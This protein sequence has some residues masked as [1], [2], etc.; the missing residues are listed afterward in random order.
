M[1]KRDGCLAARYQSLTTEKMYHTKFT[2]MNKLKGS[3]LLLLLFTT[4]T[5]I[6][7]STDIVINR[8]AAAIMPKVIEW[9]RY[10]H[11]Y[12]ELS[13]REFQTSKYIAEYL[14]SLGLEVQTG[15]AK[16]GVV[17]LLKGGKPGPVVALRADMDALPVLERS[18]LAYASTVKGE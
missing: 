16:T 6:A 4:T 11:Q 9:R 8:E 15:V 18:K 17:A 14:T 5:L 2:L 3:Q 10:L 7:Q 12:P 1:G 13:N